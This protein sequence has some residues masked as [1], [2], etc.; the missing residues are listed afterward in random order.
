MCF[1]FTVGAVPPSMDG[2]WERERRP[3]ALWNK[4]INRLLRNLVEEPDQDME[5]GSSRAPSLRSISIR[6]FLILSDFTVLALP[7][8][9]LPQVSMHIHPILCGF[10]THK[11][12]LY[13]GRGQYRTAN[14]R[15]ICSQHFNSHLHHHM[16][17]SSKRYNGNNI[18]HPEKRIG[19][20]ALRETVTI[21]SV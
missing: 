12:S 1:R 7:A 21:S 5:I 17:Q 10:H 13:N 18:H 6:P 20:R 4:K 16:V 11:S 14:L 3:P 8:C 2:W 19:P 9:S 15:H